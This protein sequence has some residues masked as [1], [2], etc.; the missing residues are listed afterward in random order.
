[1][2]DCPNEYELSTVVD[3][4]NSSVRADAKPP[5]ARLA[6]LN[7]AARAGVICKGVKSRKNP[8]RD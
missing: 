7:A 5:T 1:M 8:L 6:N 2:A 4:I 3:I